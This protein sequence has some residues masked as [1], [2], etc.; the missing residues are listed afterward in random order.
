MRSITRALV[1]ATTTLSV[2][3]T[4]LAAHADDWKRNHGHGGYAYG[5]GYR[6]AHGGYGHR[7]YDHGRHYDRRDHYNYRKD[8]HGD[9]IVAGVAGLAIGALIGSAIASDRARTSPP[10]ARYSPPRYDGY[11]WRD[12]GY[13]RRGRI[14]VSREDVWDAYQRRYISVETSRY[15]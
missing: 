1:A 5:D 2:L 10:P 3:A 13:D 11:G 12:D 8:D 6:Y 9:A 15:C 7:A 14:C 4:P